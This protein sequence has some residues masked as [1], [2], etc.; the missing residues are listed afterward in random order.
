MEIMNAIGLSASGMR[1][2]S[3]RLR[4]IAENMANADTTGDT[5]GADPYRRKTISFKSVYDKELGADKVLTKPIGLDM[6]TKFRSKY[7]P[8]S[9]AADANG[10]VKMPNVDTIMEV[11]DMREAQ[12]SYEANLGMVDIARSMLGRTVDLLRA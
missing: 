4:V 3:E 9:P 11:M 6:N 7:E 2:Q 5:P 1:A 12:R 8:G 10:Y